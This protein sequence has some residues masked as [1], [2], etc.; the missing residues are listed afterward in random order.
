MDRKAVKKPKVRPYAN[1]GLAGLVASNAKLHALHSSGKAGAETGADF[2]RG[3]SASEIS[4]SVAGCSSIGTASPFS[5]IVELISHGSFD[6]E[7][8]LDG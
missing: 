1:S 6:G 3:V 7:H 8:S 2:G 5:A 4:E